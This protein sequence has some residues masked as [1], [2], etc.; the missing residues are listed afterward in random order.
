MR[1]NGIYKEGIL[2]LPTEAIWRL[3]EYSTHEESP[4]VMHLAIFGAGRV[5][6]RN[7]SEFEGFI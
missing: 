2:D 3:F 7:C 4:T 5:Y 1:Y 6:G